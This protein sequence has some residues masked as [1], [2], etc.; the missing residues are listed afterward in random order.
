MAIFPSEFLRVFL[1]EGWSLLHSAKSHTQK[2]QQLLG[3]LPTDSSLA[4]INSISDKNIGSNMPP[5]PPDFLTT[6]P[7]AS[8]VQNYISINC[9]E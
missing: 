7:V 1:L 3:I 2:L 8:V 6:S 9:Y 4:L 5:S